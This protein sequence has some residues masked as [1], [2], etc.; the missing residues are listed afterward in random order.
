MARIAFI[1]A[2]STVFT[3]NLVGDV[4]GFRALADGTTFALM[5]IDAER[6]RTSELMVRRLI[7]AHDAHARV[8]TNVGV[9]GLIVEAALTRPELAP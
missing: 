3:R 7:G 6:L 9:Q 2:G 5:D 8:D 1:G 4:L